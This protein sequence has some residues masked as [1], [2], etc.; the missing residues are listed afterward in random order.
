VPSPT[1][2]TCWARFALTSNEH[3]RSAVGVRREA[4]GVGRGA[5]SLAPSASLATGHYSL[6]TRHYSL[7][8]C[9]RQ[10]TGRGCSLS[11]T[12]MN[13]RGLPSMPLVLCSVAPAVLV[14]LPQSQCP[15]DLAGD[16]EAGE[17]QAGHVD[18]GILQIVLLRP[19]REGLAPVERGIEIQSQIAGDRQP[20]GEP[21]HVDPEP[22]PGGGDHEGV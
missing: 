15:L 21:D 13:R 20:R 18:V 12:S 19:S 6:A 9:D 3:G 17:H 10:V 11:T 14:V 2:T 7:P 16:D 1:L 5:L 8:S 4:W 22:E